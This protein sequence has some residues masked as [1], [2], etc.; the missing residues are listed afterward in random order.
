MRVYGET[1]GVFPQLVLSYL[2][3][4]FSEEQSVLLIIMSFSPL[5]C[6]HSMWTTECCTSVTRALPE[7]LSNFESFY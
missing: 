3:T 6:Y 2:T 1:S 4:A 5:Q 7:A